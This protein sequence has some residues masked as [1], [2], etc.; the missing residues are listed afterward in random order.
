MAAVTQGR[1]VDPAMQPRYSLPLS[2]ESK[3]T[4]TTIL[5]LLAKF[6]DEMHRPV[7]SQAPKK[8]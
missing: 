7:C 4:L 8:I 3:R 2:V 5:N 1:K 6:G